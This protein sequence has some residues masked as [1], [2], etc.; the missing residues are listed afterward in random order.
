MTLQTRTADQLYT[1]L[2]GTWKGPKR[3]SRMTGCTDQNHKYID[4]PT[5]SFSRAHFAEHLAGRDTY[6]GTLG[7]LGTA[8]SGC[9]DYDDAGEDE[10][11]AA[12]AAAATKG[13]TAAA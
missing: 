9:K 8:W 7:A 2:F 1:A 11:V 5:Y 3:A 12:L 6:A 4:I 13:I 10:I